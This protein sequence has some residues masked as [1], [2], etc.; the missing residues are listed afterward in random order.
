MELRMLG[1]SHILVAQQRNTKFLENRMIS[2]SDQY[3]N[4]IFYDVH[5]ESTSRLEN[6]L[7]I[8]SDIHSNLL[9]DSEVDY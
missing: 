7:L 4:L 5:T 2:G 3:W 9:L 8:L 1:L 6:R